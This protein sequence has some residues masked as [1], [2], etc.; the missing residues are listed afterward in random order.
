MPVYKVLI[1]EDE[2]IVAK[3]IEYTLRRLGYNPVGVV[4]SG[5]EAVLKAKELQPDIILMDITLCGDMSG[6]D[7]ARE[8]NASAGTPVIYITAHLDKANPRMTE[9]TGNIYGYLLKPY[10]ESGLA[11]A[12][13]SAMRYHTLQEKLKEK[14]K[15]L[16]AAMDSVPDGIITLDANRKIIFLNRSAQSLLHISPEDT[17]TGRRLSEYGE[18]LKAGSE[19]IADIFKEDHSGKKQQLIFKCTHG[20]VIAL[21]VEVQKQDEG[22]VLAISRVLKDEQEKYSQASID[23]IF[24]NPH[25]SITVIDQDY[26]ITSFNEKA[27]YISLNAR[28]RSLKLNEN[29]LEYNFGDNFKTTVDAVFAGEARTHVYPIEIENEQTWYE[30]NYY[31]VIIDGKNAGVCITS[32]DITERKRSEEALQESEE[33]YKAVVDNLNE[34]IVITD[35]ND[36]IM[37]V[38]RRMTELS[39]YNVD[40]LLHR[41]VD[42]FIPK[43]EGLENVLRERMQQRLEGIRGRY[44]EQLRRKDGSVIWVEISAAPFLDS[45]G[46]IV[47]SIGVFSDITTRVAAEEAARISEE[48]YRRLI[49]NAPVGI[50]RL[51]LKDNQFEVVNNAFLEQTGL[52]LEGFDDKDRKKRA[53]MIHADDIDRVA[54]FSLEWKDQGFQGFRH[55]TYRI[56]NQNI[57]DWVWLDTFSYADFDEDD[58]AIAINQI[59]I[60]V[61][62]LKKAEAALADTLQE[63]FRNTIRN[64]QII[65]FKFYRRDDG[66]YAYSLREGKLAGDITS[67]K[68][69]G[70][71]PLE[72][73]DYYSADSDALVEE[74][75]S[76]KAVQSEQFYEGRWRM[77]IY[78]PIFKDGIVS[79]VV[80]SSIDISKLKEAE[81]QLQ[82]SEQRYKTLLEY[83][84]VGILQEETT[85]TGVRLS[86]YA[87]PAFIKHSGYTLEEFRAFK[88]GEISERIHPDDRTSALQMFREWRNAADDALLHVTYRFKDKVGHYRWLDNYIIKFPSV[89]GN[90][91]LQA[92]LDVTEQ[93]NNEANLRTTTS[94]LSTLIANLQAGTLV[95]D[96]HCRAVL[97]NQN[98]CSIFGLDM[99][100]RELLGENCREADE[101]LKQ[102]FKEPELFIQRIDSI[103]SDRHIV[104]GE[105]LE[106]TDGRTVERDFIPIFVD[107]IYQGHLWQYRDVTERKTAERELRRALE[108]ERELG[109]L[110]SRLV[111]TISHEFRTPLTGVLM[112]AELL[113]AYS[114]NM[115]KEQRNTEIYKIKSRVDDLVSLLNDFL[116]QSSATTL[117]ERFIPS[118][119]SIDEI[120]RK[121]ASAIQEMLVGRKQVLHLD[122][123]NNLPQ[124]MGDRRILQYIINNLLSNAS[125]YSGAGGRIDFEVKNAA[126]TIIISIKD[127]GIGIPPGE[128]AKLFAPYYRASN[129]GNISGTGLGLSTVKEF[130]DLHNGTIT[131]ESEPGKFTICTVV[132][133]VIEVL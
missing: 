49:D 60:D 84:P 42:T 8:I 3:D 26:R 110:R 16:S 101:R 99:Q 102:L 27:S 31:P 104:A 119:V 121:T 79:E 70:K 114:E 23:A 7:A 6:I 115:T 52:P 105:E 44:S 107:D 74:A 41:T 128:I 113:E 96:E 111:S 124:T 28:G 55:I 50:T 87:N 72:I 122:I 22:F 127:E 32:V 64:L 78:E 80:G 38:N 20:D 37:F 53:S 88:S 83:L 34:G 95:E 4:R 39:D 36:N 21:T 108:K 12:I 123:E 91:Q 43:R 67:E 81:H 118:V 75:F 30:V 133:P 100:P 65:V 68:V 35:E 13:E 25:L 82:E 109:I 17:Y 98:F 62:E 11:M 76:G 47:G 131:I 14:E 71:N 77:V 33:K 10:E 29:I 24:N 94:R 63:D 40:D 130:V 9:I 2:L 132:I 56:F 89:R 51:L 59:S 116:L 85:A 103:L 117:R 1:A 58:K 93:K 69:R 92:A 61:T 129:V 120:A 45:T 66:K 15:L 86:E 46:K 18:F 57:N 5:E 97:I 90:I 48:K 73:F 125:K 106:M 126:D 54:K 19:E 112:S